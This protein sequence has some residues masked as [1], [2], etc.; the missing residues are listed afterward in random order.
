MTK[1][2]KNYLSLFDDLLQSLFEIRDS[3][4]NEFNEIFKKIDVEEVNKALNSITVSHDL[5][6]SYTKL[7]QTMFDHN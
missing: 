1:L 7:L 3:K 2:R 4:L 5:A 6:S